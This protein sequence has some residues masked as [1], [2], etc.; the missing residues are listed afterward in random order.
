MKINKQIKT[1]A[2]Q[3]QKRKNSRG[4]T[5]PWHPALIK[6]KLKKKKEKKQCLKV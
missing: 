2:N 1:S 3:K 4:E 6:E 5:I